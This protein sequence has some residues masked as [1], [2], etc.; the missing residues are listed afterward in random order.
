MVAHDLVDSRKSK[1]EIDSH[2]N[3]FPVV[4]NCLI[5]N[6][7]NRPVSVYSYNPSKTVNASKDYH[8]SHSGHNY[9]LINQAIQ[10]NGLENTYEWC[11]YL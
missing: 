11:A 3:T 1:V 4:E 8:N 2:A 9:I 7:N 10:I 6:D 5:I